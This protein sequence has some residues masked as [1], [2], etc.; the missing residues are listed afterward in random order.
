VTA[1]VLPF[2]PR[3]APVIA[4]PSRSRL[5][6]GDIVTRRGHDE[7]GI[8]E[9]QGLSDIDGITFAHV[10]FAAGVLAAPAIGFVIV[11]SGGGDHAA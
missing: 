4:F 6:V 3:P 5:A 11:I 8:G 1:A 2:P 10:L 7:L 9:V